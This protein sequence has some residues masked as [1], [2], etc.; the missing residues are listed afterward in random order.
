VKTKKTTSRTVGEVVF[1]RSGVRQLLV[2]FIAHASIVLK[3][4]DTIYVNTANL[5][6]YDRD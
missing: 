2:Q 4:R 6:Y 1:L 5:Y 3:K